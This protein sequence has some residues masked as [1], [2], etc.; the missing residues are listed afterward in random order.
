MNGEELDRIL[1]DALASYSLQEPR[2]GL[3]GRVVARVRADGARS[4]GGWFLIAVPAAALACLVIAMV[5]WRGKLWL[6]ET[7]PRPVARG[8]QPVVMRVEK[9]SVP[10]R[11]TQR[12][13][14]PQR[15]EHPALRRVESFPVSFTLTAEER[16]LVAIARQA[17]KVARQL[18]QS[19]KPLEIEAINIQPVQI[20][21]VQIG[22]I[23]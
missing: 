11:E 17:P 4:R 8:P 23:Q 2:A 3:S 10:V 20:D 1:D 18:A 9:K 7:L 21:G 13:E 14:S 22:E 19:D 5:M 12:R 16:A 6:G 15:A